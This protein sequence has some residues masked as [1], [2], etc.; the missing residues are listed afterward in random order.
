METVDFLVSSVLVLIMFGIG[1]SLTL[2]EIGQVILKPKALLV[3]LSSQM[4]LLPIIAFTISISLNIP[5]YI[6]IGL[7]ILAASPGGTTSGFI[8]FLFKGNTAL[9]IMLTTIN[10]ILVLFSIPLIVNFA[11][12]YFYGNSTDFNLPFLN[13]VKEIF[14]LTAIPVSAGVV[15]RQLN[16]KYALIISKYS[17]PVLMVLL[18]IV[19]VIKFLGGSEGERITMAEIIEILPYAL[20]LNILCFL[21]GYCISKIFNLGFK[22]LITTS[23]ESSVHNTTMAFLISGN[24]LHNSQF[25]KVSLIYA[26][27]SFWTAILFCL[28]I[29]WIEQYKS[30]TAYDL[31]SPSAQE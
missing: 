23:I 3:S 12:V 9:S 29:S 31:V 26:M 25:G 6:R 1:I 4:I 22:N 20:L 28:T 14:A 10:S 30:R 19:F 24:L 8:T 2:T 18:G 7:I 11:I 16:K 5:N 15:L 13:T 21:T 17:K 27:F